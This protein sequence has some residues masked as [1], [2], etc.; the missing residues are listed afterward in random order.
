MPKHI[1]ILHTVLATKNKVITVQELSEIYG[2]HPEDIAALAERNKDLVVTNG[3]VM[4]K[5]E[6][7]LIA[8]F[9]GAG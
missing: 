5:R 4:A 6:K 2:E 9:V 8:A 7:A 3:V 1:E